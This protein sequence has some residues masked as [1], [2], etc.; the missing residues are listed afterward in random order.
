MFNLS[1]TDSSGKT[2]HFFRRLAAFRLGNEL[3]ELEGN[4]QLTS[5]RR[6]EF[7]DEPVGG[8]AAC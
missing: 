2:R 6:D 3:N 1:L 4:L 8:F 5:F 7:F